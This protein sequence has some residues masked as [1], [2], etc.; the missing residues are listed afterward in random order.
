[1]KNACTNALHYLVF[2][3]CIGPSEVMLTSWAK[4]PAND[5]Q[6]I[7]FMAEKGGMCV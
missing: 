2:T 5:N 1:M 3:L 7:Q 6:N 4:H